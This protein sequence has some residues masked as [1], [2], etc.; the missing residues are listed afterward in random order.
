MAFKVKTTRP[1]WYAVRPN[2]DVIAA[3]ESLAF[4]VN[5]V[6]DMKN[7]MI[8][9]YESG[10]SEEDLSKHLFL[11]QGT[12]IDAETFESV[13]KCEAK[14]KVS[15]LTSIW[16]NVSKESKGKNNSGKQLKVAVKYEAVAGSADQ[17]SA[18][19]KSLQGVLLGA[20][21]VVENDGEPGSKTVS[22][23]YDR[24]RRTANKNSAEYSKGDRDQS[25]LP[26]N[27]DGAVDALRG[28]RIKYK[29]AANYTMQLTKERDIA[30]TKYDK[31]QR[32]IA[33]E[34]RNASRSLE[35]QRNADAE[36]E[37]KESGVDV[38]AL[39]SDAR[40]EFS[41]GIFSV[42]IVVVLAYL[43]GR[44]LSRSYFFEGYETGSLN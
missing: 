42:A 23:T 9:N 35:S 14:E 22:D 30:K 15:Q 32:D 4:E 1:A 8:F 33:A 40:P 5:L 25:S 28:L 20:S 43:F 34:A 29:K 18:D 44:F 27:Q 2:Q 38:K 37:S 24:L 10:Q 19:M 6:N 11:V 39:D 16:E 36:E 26:T 12:A 3:G 17:I 41:P 21:S 31:L 13:V 7:Q